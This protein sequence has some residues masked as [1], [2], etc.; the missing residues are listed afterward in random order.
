MENVIEDIK[1]ALNSQVS[2]RNQAILHLKNVEN[3]FRQKLIEHKENV[4]N[5]INA[6]FKVLEAQLMT[7][8]LDC[9]DKF[10]N[11]FLKYQDSLFP[12]FENITKLKNSIENQKIFM[13][14]LSEE[15]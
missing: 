14:Y 4:K 9:F 8:K 10:E 6:F 5:E 7:A 13:K 3:V 11:E 12:H 2:K 15:K 1:K